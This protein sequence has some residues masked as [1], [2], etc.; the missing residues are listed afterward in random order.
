VRLAAAG[1]RHCLVCESVIPEGVTLK[2]KCCSP[3]CS[4]IYQNR[5]RAEEKR[6][7]IVASRQPCPACGGEI[8]AEYSGKWK[9]CSTACKRR[10]NAAI[11]RQRSPHYMRQ[12][13]YGRV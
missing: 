4:E 5:K 3:K 8:P 11:W 2:A 9:Y 1:E 12:Y 13:M 7:R 6:A 10:T